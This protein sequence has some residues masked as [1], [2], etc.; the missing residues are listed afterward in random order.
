MLVFVVFAVD[1]VII[2]ILIPIIIIIGQKVSSLHHPESKGVT[3]R[4]KITL[5]QPKNPVT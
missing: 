5:S 2:I 1:V 3:N 4:E